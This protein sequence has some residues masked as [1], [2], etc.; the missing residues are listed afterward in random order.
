[1]VTAKLVNLAGLVLGDEDGGGSL[2]V[3]Q[4]GR[5]TD[6][7]VARTAGKGALREGSFSC[8]V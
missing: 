5:G 1:M 2:G 7:A 6:L 3:I 4:A 8:S